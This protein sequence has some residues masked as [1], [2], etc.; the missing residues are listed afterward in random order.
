MILGERL[1]FVLSTEMDA[2]T[3]DISFSFMDECEIKHSSFAL[4]NYTSSQ[5]EKAKISKQNQF[6]FKPASILL[7]FRKI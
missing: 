1:D 4:L 5:E 3:Y 7:S 6:N 2:K